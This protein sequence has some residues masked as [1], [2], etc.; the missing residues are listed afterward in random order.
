M[1]RKLLAPPVFPDDPD[2][3]RDARLL[4]QIIIATMAIPILA[5]TINLIRPTLPFVI[6]ANI[7]FATILV[8]LLFL[9]RAGRARLASMIIV[10]VLVFQSTFFNVLTGGQIRPFILVTVIAILMSGLLLG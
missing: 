2:K 5:I 4:H 10:S 8:L 1:P 9:N 3:T 7:V 6:P